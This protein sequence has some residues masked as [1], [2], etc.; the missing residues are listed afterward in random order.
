MLGWLMFHPKKKTSC[1]NV[2]TDWRKATDWKGLK[3]ANWNLDLTRQERGQSTEKDK[4]S[5]GQDSNPLSMPS[6][7]EPQRKWTLCATQLL[8]KGS[9][10]PIWETQILLRE[11]PCIYF[12]ITHHRKWCVCVCVCGGGGGGC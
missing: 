1:G 5:I 11:L 3:V 12:E 8:Y 7:A 2:Q 6:T 10:K 9:I 4:D